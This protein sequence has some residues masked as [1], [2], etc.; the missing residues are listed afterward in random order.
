MF[1]KLDKIMLLKRMVLVVL[2]FCHNYFLKF[3]HFSISNV[4]YDEKFLFARKDLFFRIEGDNL[5]EKLNFLFVV[6]L[7]N[8]LFWYLPITVLN[9]YL[10]YML[11]TSLKGNRGN[12][13]HLY[14]YRILQVFLV[15]TVLA[16]FLNSCGSTLFKDD[17][18]PYSSLILL[19]VFLGNFVF[20]SLFIP[21]WKWKLEGWLQT[22]N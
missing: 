3:F 9:T 16:L 15:W 11:I 10:F 5:F 22:P 12:V 18:A 14:S 13:L 1:L 21:L 8:D 20:A 4:L 7:F 2:F 6:N 17:L 19:Y